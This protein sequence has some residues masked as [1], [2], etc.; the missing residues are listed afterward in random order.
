MNSQAQAPP[1][2]AMTDRADFKRAVQQMSRALRDSQ[3]GGLTER[4]ESVSKLLFTKI[5]DELEAKDGWD[6][7]PSKTGPQVR[8]L[9]GDTDRTAYERAREVWHRAASS[10]PKVFGGHRS[11]FP[12]DVVGV[13]RIIRLLDGK[14]LSDLPEDTKGAAYEELLRNTFEKNENQ[15]YFTPRHV[16]D[17]IVNLCAP[18]ITDSVCDPACGSGGFLVGALSNVAGD[19]VARDTF[20]RCMRGAEVDERMAWITR[21]NMLLHGGSPTTIFTLPGA[22]SLGSLKAIR[23]A[24]PPESFS[25]ILTNPPFGSD[26]TDAAGLRAFETGEGRT[27]RRRGVLFVERCLQL[28]APGGRLAIVLDDSVLNLPKNADIRRIIR[29]DAIVDAVI[30]LPDVTFMPYSTA[31]SSILVLR[32][33]GDPGDEQG[34]V[35]MADVE[36]VGNRPNGDPLYSDERDAAGKRLLKSDL[37]AVLDKYRSWSGAP[38]EDYVD[39]TV[40]FGCDVSRYAS[41]QDGERLDVFFFHPA[42]GH[43]RSQLSRSAHKLARLGDVAAIDST[44]VSPSDDF[45]DGIVRWIGLGDIESFTSQYEVKELLADRIKSNAHVFRSDDILFARL[46]PKLRKV[47][48]IPASD[49]GGIC[50]AELLVI[51]IS[52]EETVLI[53]Y[54]GYM[55]RSELTYGQ[56]IF[57]VTGIGRPRVSAAALRDV[58]IPVPPLSAQRRLVKRLRDADERALRLRERAGVQLAEAKAGSDEAFSEAIGALCPTSQG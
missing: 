10:H 12:S 21:L 44:T 33:R 6:G 32:R 56:L 30:S 55:L 50:S 28:L 53:D 41:D 24:L 25:L 18:S 15:Q 47:V 14:S 46:R 27:S 23:A 17:F 1:R 7:L 58:L 29:R 57:K 49:A 4:F 34:A 20:A 22:G 13:A 37:G 38:F 54:V 52:D 51:R 5:V 31:K 8:W 39:G 9:P 11:Q 3:G 26:M 42:R 2:L 43:A 36:H 48:R 45:A 16:V 40:I 35:F 19:Q